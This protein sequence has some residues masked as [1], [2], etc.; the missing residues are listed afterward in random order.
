V[1]KLLENIQVFCFSES[2]VLVIVPS[3]VEVLLNLALE[4]VV[5]SLVAIEFHEHSK[6]FVEHV[7]FLNFI[8]VR[9][10]L[11][12]NRLENT[13]DVRKDGDSKEKHHSNEDPLKV[14]PG[15]VVS[16]SNCR[17]RGKH[18]VS[19]SDRKFSGGTVIQLEI[20]DEVFRLKLIWVLELI[21]IDIID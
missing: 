11:S 13:H 14:T 15:V 9:L 8:V 12:E 18:V 19:H 6:K 17:Q 3:V 16:K 10:K 4:L 2:S 5:K 7:S 20:A 21:I 1:R